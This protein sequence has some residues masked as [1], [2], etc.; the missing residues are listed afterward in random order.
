MSDPSSSSSPPAPS[1]KGLVP[2]IVGGVV[3]SATAFF[4]TTSPNA[5]P[6]ALSFMGVVGAVLG[7]VLSVLVA[8]MAWVLTIHTP[9]LWFASLAVA[10]SCFCG[11]YKYRRFSSPFTDKVG[12]AF[13]VSLLC[14]L[15][16]GVTFIEGKTSRIS[17][18]A[19]AGPE[20]ATVVSFDA[21]PVAELIQ[22]NRKGMPWRH[23]KFLDWMNKGVETS[24]LGYPTC[25]RVVRGYQNSA[26]VSVYRLEINGQ[27]I[28]ASTPASVCSAV[29]VSNAKLTKLK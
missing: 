6:L 27:Q 24:W 9:L 10:L 8:V 21:V 4:L 20:P 19:E 25:S 22:E 26:A 29:M 16:A 18:F 23:R 13:A 3:V 17:A 28:N 2:C 12:M 1:L 5:A 14:L 7:T 15:V 11:L